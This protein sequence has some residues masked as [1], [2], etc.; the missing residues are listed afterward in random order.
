[1]RTG[2]LFRHRV[3]API[4][5]GTNSAPQFKEAT[6][7][8]A[9][10]MI[11]IRTRRKF[12]Q[13]KPVGVAAIAQRQGYDKPSALVLDTEMEGLLTW[14]V[15]GLQRCLERG[16]F[17][18]P[19]EV[20]KEADAIALD[21]NLVAGFVEEC[22][23][24]DRNGMLA[25]PDF[26]AAFTVWWLENKGDDARIPSSDRIGRALSDY[27]E[28]RLAVD[29]R[30]LRTNARRFYA[31]MALNFDGL[32]YWKDAHES[33]A[34]QLKGRKTGMT[35]AGDRP[36]K[37][38]PGN[39]NDKPA[40]KVMRKAYEVGVWRGDT[41]EKKGDVSEK[42]SPDVSPTQVSDSKRKPRF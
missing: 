23:D 40:I 20:R 39:W 35:P 31:G 11:I 38:I 17:Q 29:P 12:D 28:P 3:R 33:E 10:R 15:E 6:R 32:R 30:E 21:G 22:I 7:A 5:W 26:S 18:I 36:N 25:V 41:S 24:Y 13:N 1:M 14:A 2:P 8:M 19:E 42:V 27:G 34:F 4:L 37:P 16:F 9:E